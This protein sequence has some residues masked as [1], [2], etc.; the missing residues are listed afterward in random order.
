MRFFITLKEKLFVEKQ[1]KRG[2]IIPLLKYIALR[3]RVSHFFFLHRIEYRMR[4]WFAPYAFWL[5]NHEQYV[6]EDELFF[7]R[8]LQEGDVVVDAGAHL[9]TLTMTASNHV[10]KTGR[11][12]ACEPHPKTY[13]Y[14]SR[15]IKDNYCSNVMLHNVAVGDISHN[16]Y[17]TSHYVSDMNR[18]TDSGTVKVS[19]STLDDLL[20]DEE[21]ITLLKLDV[22]GYELPALMGAKQ[23]LAKTDAVYFESAALSF[24]E[25]GYSLSDIIT[26]LKEC[27]FT[28]YKQEDNFAL[29]EIGLDHRTKERYENL[30][31]LKDATLYT[32]RII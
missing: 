20:K 9:G 5:W 6:R 23:I 12:I 30:I 32:S 24:K 28:T 3:L 16:V 11:V 10:G 26:L 2:N 25:R 7:S 1:L 27:G 14:L 18:V 22:E 15:N 17:M 13:Q 21:H 29:Q 8:F 31:A 4:V 19:M